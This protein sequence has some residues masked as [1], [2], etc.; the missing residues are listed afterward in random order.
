LIGI[1]Q[2]ENLALIASNW[3]RGYA[4]GWYYNLRANPTAPVTIGDQPRTYA[5]HEATVDEYD[6]YWQKAVEMYAGYA[7]YEQRAGRHIP[8]MVLTPAPR[9]ETD[10]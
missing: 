3:G 4:P 5:A 10:N 9:S 6:T 7:A 8:I 1:P 2:G